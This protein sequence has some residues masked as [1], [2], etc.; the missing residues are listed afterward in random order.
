MIKLVYCVAK[1]SDLSD[2]EFF[3]YWLNNH[4]PL[5]KRFAA[6]IKAEKYVQSHTISTPINT[7]L[8]ASR[9]LD[10]PYDGVTEIWFKDLETA[11][12]VLVDPAAQEALQAL[13]QD[14]ATFV[15]FARSS[16]FLTEEHVI[17]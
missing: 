4:G 12:G 15:D 5:V 6:A 13:I 17:F 7:A 3:A 16:M 14:E 8:Q 1:R 10:M 9:S 2:E 11:Q